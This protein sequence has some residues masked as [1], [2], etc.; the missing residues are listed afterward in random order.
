MG[1]P[2]RRQFKRQRTGGQASSDTA[3]TGFVTAAVL[4][5]A[6]MRLFGASYGASPLLRRLGRL[7]EFGIMAEHQRDDERDKRA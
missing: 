7:L 5:L 2:R 6:S 1:V 3:T 4:I